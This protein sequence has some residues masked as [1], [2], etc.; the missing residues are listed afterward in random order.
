[1]ERATNEW[2]TSGNGSWDWTENKEN[3]TQFFVQG[4]ERAVGRESYLTIGMRGDTDV[5]LAGDDPMAILTD[6]I[7]TQRS[8]VADVYG[9]ETGVNQV[10]ALY[11]EV[12]ALYEAGLEVSDDV[13]LLFSDDNFGNLRRLPT[14][15][16]RQRAG[17]TGVCI[18]LFWVYHLNL[19]LN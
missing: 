18:Y 17:G 1:M 14:E 16:E 5:P 6:V 13:T 2:L 10:W 9:N 4:A 8:I 7:A 11:K 19:R 3:I 15:A 12:Q